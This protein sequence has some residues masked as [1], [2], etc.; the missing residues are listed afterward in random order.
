MFFKKKYSMDRNTANQTLQNV[1]A[2][3]N[4][5]PNTIPFDKLVLKGLAQTALVKV[6]KWSAF[7][8]LLLVL[9]APL[10]F[11]NSE[12]TVSSKGFG[13]RIAIENHRLYADH[14]IM[15]LSG[16][17]IDY[18]NIYAKKPDGTVVFPVSAD[19]D[20]GSVVIPYDG[21]SLNIYIPDNSGNVLQALLSERTNQ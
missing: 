20:S 13:Q 18:E 21:N 2:A 19:P 11:Q 10:A 16:G 8:F 5:P 9:L 12:F 6:C 3:C 1:F 15:Q 14:F 4:Q 17:S 7:C